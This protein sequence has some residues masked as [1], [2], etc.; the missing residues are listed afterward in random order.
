M[1][2]IKGVGE[3]VPEAYQVRW[4]AE[5][6]VTIFRPLGCHSYNVKHLRNNAVKIATIDTMLSFYLAFLFASGQEFDPERY[7]C[8]SEY[9]F[10]VQRE[11]RLA[12]RG[13][14]KR[15]SINCYGDQTTL[16]KMRR[17]KSKKY[18]ELKNKKGSKE[19]EWYFLR[20]VPAERSRKSHKHPREKGGANEK[21]KR[22]EGE[23]GV[24]KLAAAP[25][26]KASR[27]NDQDKYYYQ[28]NS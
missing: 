10:Q 11:N 8:M 26:D 18:E 2:K 9:L 27:D 23:G 7:R 21:R 17:E 6:L 12:Q 16:E 13:I 15:F 20:Y 22:G 1:V 24:R 25:L 19:Y 14:L 28:S 4:G 5:R 3:I